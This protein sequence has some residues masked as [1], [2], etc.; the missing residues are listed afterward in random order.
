MNS[1]R[2]MKWG[3]LKLNS[4]NGSQYNFLKNYEKVVTCLFSS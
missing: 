4:L 2:I 3:M 1:I